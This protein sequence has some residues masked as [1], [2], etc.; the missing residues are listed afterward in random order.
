MDHV[1]RVVIDTVNFIRARGLNHRQFSAFLLE[2]DIHHGLPYHTDVRWLSRGAVLKHFYKLRTEI[3]EFMQGKGKPVVQ[4]DD[5][6]WTRDLAFLVDI[7]EHLNVLNVTMQGRNK[8]VTEYYDSVRAFQGKLVLWQTQ[9]SKRNAAHFPCL[10]SQPVNHQ[11]MD[12]YANLLSGLR[13]EFDNRFT[14]FTELEKDFSLFRSPFT[15]DAS[16]VPEAMQ[17]ELIELQCCA[18]LKDTYASV[19]IEVFYQSLPPQYPMLT[20]FAGKIL[21]MF[22]TT[23]LCEQAFSVMNINKSKVRN[24]LTHGHLNDVMKIATAQQLSPDMDKLVKV[25]RCLASTSKM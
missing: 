23:Y 19:A 8:L 5:P 12:K 3:A 24:R 21:C 9:L 11:S 22:G 25:K 10:K 2:N 14:V 20:A 16:V 13:H 18:P 4:L 1:M 15:V 6:E 17:M 7:T